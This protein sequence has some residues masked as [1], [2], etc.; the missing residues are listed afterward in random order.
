[1]VDSGQTH[2]EYLRK[3][4]SDEGL[5]KGADLLPTYQGSSHSEVRLIY[6]FLFA[7]EFWKYDWT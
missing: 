6:R 3:V 7:L 2:Q 5:K 1:M 4:I